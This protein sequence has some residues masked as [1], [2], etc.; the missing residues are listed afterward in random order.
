MLQSSLVMVSSKVLHKLQVL[1]MVP[2]PEGS[3]HLAQYLLQSN[4]Q[5]QVGNDAE[6][7]GNDG[8]AHLAP[9]IIPSIRTAIASAI[10]G[11]Q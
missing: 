11:L 2:L 9:P 1:L 8:T 5:T 10:A 4:G 7:N 6:L 3:A